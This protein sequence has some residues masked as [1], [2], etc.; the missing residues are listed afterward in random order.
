MIAAADSWSS[1]PLG[2]R[3]SGRHQQHAAAAGGPGGHPSAA[4][5]SSL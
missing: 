1:A 3:D 5:S 4:L 2:H